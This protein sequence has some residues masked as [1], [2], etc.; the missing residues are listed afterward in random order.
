MQW[1]LPTGHVLLSE[2]VAGSAVVMS[3]VHLAPIELWGGG[4]AINTQDF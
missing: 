2:L 4:N 3:W 1:A